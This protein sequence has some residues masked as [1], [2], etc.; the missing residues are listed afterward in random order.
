MTVRRAILGFAI[1]LSGT[2]RAAEQPFDVFEAVPGTWAISEGDTGPV[3]PDCTKP[4]EII[5]ISADRKTYR[6]SLSDSTAK[7]VGTGEMSFAIEYVSKP[8][9]D[10]KGKPVIWILVMKG[11]DS[12]YWQRR[13]WQD[14][15]TVMR[16]RCTTTR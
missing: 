1:L 7:I 15:R 8:Q 16:S 4:S 6:E 3:E 2:G 14:G 9:L 10:D 13:D 5:S 11:K 12:F